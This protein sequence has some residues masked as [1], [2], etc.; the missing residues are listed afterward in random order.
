MALRPFPD[1]G[2][3]RSP[4]KWGVFDVAAA[5]GLTL[6]LPDREVPRRAWHLLAAVGA[7][8]EIR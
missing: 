3:M 1:S 4:A 6:D 8:P 7:A 2:S 5:R